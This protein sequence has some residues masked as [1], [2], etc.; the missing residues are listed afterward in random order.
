[1]TGDTI[2][3]PDRTSVTPSSADMRVTT[4]PNALPQSEGAV[5]TSLPAP[6]LTGVASAPAELALAG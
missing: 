6:T 3:S 5:V 4:A 1:M 2:H